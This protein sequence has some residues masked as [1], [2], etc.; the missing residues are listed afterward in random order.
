MSTKSCR[1]KVC[2]QSNPQPIENFRRN[3]NRPGGLDDYCKACRARYTSTKEAKIAKVERNKKY[4]QTTKGREA[5]KRGNAKYVAKRSETRATTPKRPRPKKVK[6]AITKQRSLGKFAILERDCFR[7]IYCG[8]SSIENGVSLEVD[9]I[10]PISLGGQDIA[11]N[12]VVSCFD[13]NQ[14]KKARALSSE[15]ILRLMSVI[16]ERN[17]RANIRDDQKI[18]T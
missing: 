13:C 6:P 11:V 17:R 2:Q 7:C 8:R 1:H 3:K 9:H 4:S 10:I 15:T 18:R 16:K 5:Q 14:T 12:L